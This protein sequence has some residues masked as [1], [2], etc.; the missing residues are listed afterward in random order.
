MAEYQEIVR[1]VLQVVEANTEAIKSLAQSLEK[2]MQTTRKLNVNMLALG[3]FGRMVQ[4]TM[5]SLLKPAAEITQIFELFG[6]ILEI[7][8]LPIMLELMPLFLDLVDYITGLNN[9]TKLFAGW[10][11]IVAFVLG[12]IISTLAFMGIGLDKLILA[13][14]DFSKSIL[15]LGTPFAIV[16]AVI[17]A[18]II[19]IFLSWKTNFG[20]IKVWAEVVVE[21]IKSMFSGLKRFFSGILDVIVGLFS[22]DTEK[23]ING[24]KNIWSGFWEFVGGGFKALLGVIVIVGLGIIRIVLS[25]IQTAIGLIL[26][27]LAKVSELVGAKKLQLTLLS[28]KDKVDTFF[29]GLYNKDFNEDINKPTKTPSNSGVNVVINQNVNANVQDM[30]AF[31]RLLNQNNQRMLDEIMAKVKASQT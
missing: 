12:G 7:L 27:G 15:K 21:G 1:I 24:L 28:A 5:E 8:F 23:L 17:I 9:E 19:G 26:S 3:F 20:K 25:I 14:S 13:F 16:A 31:D 29:E 22:G 10:I 30:S 6:L 11:A 18:I 4:N 2:V